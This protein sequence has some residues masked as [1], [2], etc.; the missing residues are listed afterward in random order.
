M[1]NQGKN[2]GNGKSTAFQSFSTQVNSRNGVQCNFLAERLS[3][4]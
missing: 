4:Q 3:T 1:G 2:T